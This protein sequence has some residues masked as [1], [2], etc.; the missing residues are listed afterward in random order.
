MPKPSD[1]VNPLKLESAAEGGDAA[2]DNLGLPAKL[3][4]EEDAVAV[5][6]LFYGESGNDGQDKLVT[7]YREGDEMFFEDTNNA[8]AGRKSLSD[9][10]TAGSGL[11]PAT[12]RDLDQLVHCIA[13]DSFDEIIRTGFLVTG[14]ITWTDAGKTTKIREQAIVYTGLLPTQITT[15]QYDGAGVAVEIVVE[16][17][18]YTGFLVSDI[19]RVRT[20]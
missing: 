13:E 1:R 15:T 17:F 8:G 10:A 6:G 9:L 5:A 20:L 7:S 12:H 14:I 4:P 3:N 2:D 18:S 16:T 19:T 11:T